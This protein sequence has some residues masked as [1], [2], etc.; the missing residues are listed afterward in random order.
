[1]LL[2]AQGELG[3]QMYSS[4]HPRAKWE[5]RNI[6]KGQ[7]LVPP[8][9]R[10]GVQIGA[11]AFGSAMSLACDPD[12]IPLLHPPQLLSDLW[13]DQLYRT[14]R[15]IASVAMWYLPIPTE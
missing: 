3:T 8:D 4:S 13:D 10:M 11:L 7:L 12:R 9:K 15:S 5:C 2:Q 14:D 1:M 6:S